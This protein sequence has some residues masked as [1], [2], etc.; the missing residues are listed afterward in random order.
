MVSILK[1]IYIVF[2]LL[3]LF[4]ALKKKRNV[5][6][7]LIY[8][9]SSMLYYFNA[10]EG[11]IFVGKLN[12]IGVESY[13]INNGTY[14]ILLINMLIAF[15]FIIVENEKDDYLPKTTLS[16]EMPVMK[17]FLLVVLVFSLYM[18]IKHNVFFRS[19]YKKSELAEESG[20]GEVYYKYLASFAFVYSFSAKNTHITIP[21]KIIGTLPIL[22]TFLFGNRSY[23]VI[24]LVAVMFDMIY[25][26]CGQFGRNLYSYLA[27]HKKI[28]IASGILVFVTLTVK[29]ITG[30]LFVKN[31]DIVIQRLSSID[32]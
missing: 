5:S 27:K 32:Y 18:C 29:G 12:Q 4:Y 10:F 28:V 24:S 20:R 7:I 13:S 26:H 11:E 14:A 8:F 30:A 2:F 31:F 1:W 17:A 21:W 19:N 22:S 3:V 9:F 15:F 25:M 6:F 16:N 23:L